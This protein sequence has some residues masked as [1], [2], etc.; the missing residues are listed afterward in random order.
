M[1]LSVLSAV[2][3]R[4]H[5]GPC[6][7]TSVKKEDVAQCFDAKRVKFENLTLKFLVD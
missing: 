4:W 3:R 1:K 2:E 7:P 5:S 6:V